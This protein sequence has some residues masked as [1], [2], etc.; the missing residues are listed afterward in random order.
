MQIGTSGEAIEAGGIVL[1]RPKS[2]SAKDYGPHLIESGFSTVEN[3]NY[4]PLKGD[5]AVF[6]NYEGGSVEGHMQMYN[7]ERWVSD[8]F[9]ER[10]LWPSGRY[11]DMNP[12]YQIF[13]WK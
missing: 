4:I 10:P 6:Q 11:M 3:T 8:H 2:A 5:V 12:S 9:Q 1:S 13:R 7:G